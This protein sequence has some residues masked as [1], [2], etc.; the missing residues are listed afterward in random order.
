MICTIPADYGPRLH[1]VRPVAPNHLTPSLL[2]RR[3]FFFNFQLWL[4]RNLNH[5]P[6]SVIINL[7]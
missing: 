1:R 6:S 3:I 7:G 5:S 2:L 4:T